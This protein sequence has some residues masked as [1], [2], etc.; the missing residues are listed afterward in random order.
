MRVAILSDIHG[1]IEALEAM[2]EV[3]AQPV[4]HRVGADVPGDHYKRRDRH[5]GEHSRHQ[6]S[7]A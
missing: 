3:A 4:V 2:L 1:N 7:V 6:T 5:A